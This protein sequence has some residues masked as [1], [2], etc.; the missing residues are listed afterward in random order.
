MILW[1]YLKCHLY[2]ADVK[3]TTR[4][5]SMY[6]WMLIVFSCLIALAEAALFCL[7]FAG[8]FKDQPN[9]LSASKPSWQTMSSSPY[10]HF[11][12]NQ[13]SAKFQQNTSQV[14]ASRSESLPGQMSKSSPHFYLPGNLSRIVANHG[15]LIRK[16]IA[17]D[18]L[19]ID[20][21]LQQRVGIL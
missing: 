3:Y 7:V 6:H 15:S 4:I 2:I 14:T 11:P 20:N 13:Q 1:E 10:A 16:S 9:E 21:F 18:L 17:L 12:S 19:F 5:S 8:K